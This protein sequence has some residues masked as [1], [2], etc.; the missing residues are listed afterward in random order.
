[1]H[2]DVYGWTEKVTQFV[3][4]VGAKLIWRQAFFSLT[5]DV[6]KAWFQRMLQWTERTWFNLTCLFCVQ[7]LID[8]FS[9]L[10]IRFDVYLH[11][12]MWHVND[13]ILY[14]IFMKIF[15][16]MLYTLTYQWTFNNKYSIRLQFPW[17]LITRFHF[18]HRYIMYDTWLWLVVIDSPNYQGWNFD[19]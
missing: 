7:N 15:N 6:L 10:I 4:K 1:M 8:S 5:Q 16:L 11:L 12:E 18:I 13:L 3:N 19:H 14:L 17:S 2:D 9:M